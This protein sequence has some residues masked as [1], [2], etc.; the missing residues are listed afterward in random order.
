MAK[1]PEYKMALIEAWRT[2][3]G[4]F[5][6]VVSAQLAVGAQQEDPWVWLRGIILAGVF[7]GVRAVVEYYRKK[8]APKEYESLVYKLPA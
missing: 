7:S 2:F 4:S 6:A 1:F 3:V 8:Y 5:L